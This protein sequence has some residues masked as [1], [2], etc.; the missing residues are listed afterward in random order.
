ME[1]RQAVKDDVPSVCAR[2]FRRLAPIEL[3]QLVRVEAP[4]FEMFADAQRTH[5]APDAIAQGGHGAVVE[6][7]PMVVRDDEHV[8]FGDVVWRVDAGSGKGFAQQKRDG[9]SRPEHGID[10]NPRAIRLQ[11]VAAVPEPDEHVARAVQAQ[12]VRL[13]DGDIAFLGHEP[14]RAFPE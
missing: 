7:V 8:D 10:Q 12:K 3:D 14:Q 6:M 11:E 1:R 2:Q 4:V 9:G 13:H 5:N